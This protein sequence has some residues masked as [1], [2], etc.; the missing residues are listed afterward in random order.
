MAAVTGKAQVD[1]LIREFMAQQLGM[2]NL[3]FFVGRFKICTPSNKII[4][5]KNKIA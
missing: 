1:E 3:S 5:K 4:H 2:P